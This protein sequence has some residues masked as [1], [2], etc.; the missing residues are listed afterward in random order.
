[1]PL[2]CTSCPIA[3]AAAAQTFITFSDAAISLHGCVCA[4]LPIGAV[5][6]SPNETWVASRGTGFQYLTEESIGLVWTLHAVAYGIE[7][8]QFYFGF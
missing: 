2:A 3:P 7:A 1:M 4:V 5:L 6:Q 8:W